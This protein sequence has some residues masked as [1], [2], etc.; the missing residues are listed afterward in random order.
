[1]KNLFV[2]LMAVMLGMPAIAANKDNEATKGKSMVKVIGNANAKTYKVL[3]M[4]NIQSKVTLAI[5]DEAGILVA[6]SHIK[7]K[8]EF[9]KPFRFENMPAGEYTIIIKDSFG[10]KRETFYHQPKD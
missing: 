5:Y 6:K 3:Y 8:S 1:M 4:A 10:M 2:I 7:D 9:L